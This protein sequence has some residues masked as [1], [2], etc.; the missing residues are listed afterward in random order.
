MWLEAILTRDDLEKA[1][2]D[3]VPFKIRLGDDGEL[4]IDEPSEVAL[5]VDLGLRVACKAQIRWPVL[6]IAVPITLDKV[7][8]LVTPVIT[9]R[10][11]RDALAFRIQIEHVDVGML[12]GLM[13]RS[14]TAMINKELATHDELS[15][16]FAQT[17]SVTA[18][19]PPVLKDLA[20]LDLA[21]AWGKVKIT[22][23]ALVFV[24]SFHTAVHRRTT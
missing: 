11:G 9:E 2:R 14:V 4:A 19:L 16:R 10:D 7:T 21:V 5:V 13:D 8:L 15:W 24:V 6:G 1:I 18:K 22:A 17:L 20:S 3:F 12:A 23:E